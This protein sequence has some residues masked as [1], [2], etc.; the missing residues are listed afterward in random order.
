MNNH[1]STATDLVARAHAHNQQVVID[2][3]C[4]SINSLITIKL[5]E[6]MARK[7]L[8]S[9][10][11]ELHVEELIHNRKIQF[12]M[13]FKSLKLSVTSGTIINLVAEDNKDAPMVEIVIGAGTDTPPIL[14]TKDIVTSVPIAPPAQE[15]KKRKPAVKFR[16]NSVFEKLSSSSKEPFRTNSARKNY[17][18]R[19]RNKITK[20]RKIVEQKTLS[21][22]EPK[23]A[24][25]LPITASSPLLK[26]SRFHPLT[27]AARAMR[28]TRIASSPPSPVDYFVK[29][30]PNE[31]HALRTR[32]LRN[33]IHTCAAQI[34]QTKEQHM[35][36]L[37]GVISHKLEK[38]VSR[39]EKSEA[40]NLTPQP[41]RRNKKFIK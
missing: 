9:V 38:E 31:K 18:R 33:I 17:L 23:T 11:R 8:F 15:D 28:V 3:I 24:E 41:M 20:L 10:D 2:D 6:P 27:T 19:V 29:R 21:L 37:K 35:R 13:G 5:S 34:G 30:T 22:V 36:H 1:L 12:G 26:G 16:V 14:E 39:E 4:V 32:M 7:L 40:K 25:K